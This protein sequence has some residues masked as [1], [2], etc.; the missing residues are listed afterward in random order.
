MRD[1]V[2]AERDTPEEITPILSY[3]ESANEVLRCAAVRALTGRGA[4]ARAALAQAL[5]DEDPD[6]RADAMEALAA[7]A[8]AQDAPLLRRSLTGDPVREVKLAAIEGLARLGDPE[9]VPLLRVLVH[10][11]SEDT[12]A[13]EDQDSDWE[14]W[15]DIQI[16]A[17]AALGRMQVSDAIVDMLEARAE[18]MAQALDVPVFDALVALG[19]AGVVSLLDVVEG[20]AGLARQR[21]VACLARL[22][23]EHLQDHV[24]ALLEADDP[25]LRIAGLRLLPADGPE[26]AAILRTDTAA[27]VR[28]A[29][30]DRAAPL[31][32]G[33]LT[34]AL[35]DADAAVQAAALRA[36]RPPLDEDFAAALADNLLAWVRGA[37]LPLMIAAA[38]ALPLWAP[39]RAQDALL[40]LVADG[41]RPL[42]ARIAA[43]RALA[44]PAVGTGTETLVSLLGNPAQ[45]VRTAVLVALTAR[46][47]AGDVVAEAAIA[48]AI[49]GVLL[50]D[51][52]AR[53]VRAAPDEAPDEAPDAATPKGE[54][55]GP[56]RIRITPDGEIVEGESQ[57]DPGGSTLSAILSEGSVQPPAPQ[58]EDTP[59]EST[60]KRRKRRPVEGPDE[61]AMALSREAMQVSADLP[62]APIG[63]ALLAQA[64]AAPGP[65]RAVAWQALDRHAAQAAL[66]EP[67][68]KTAQSAL[69]DADPVVRH[70]AYRLR[71]RAS[72]D[73]A[74]LARAA[75]EADPLIR[76]MAV[77]HLPLDAVQSALG[78]PALAVRRAAA[79]R[80]LDLAGPEDI[81]AAV[82][83][84]VAAERSDTLAELIGASPRARRA[85]LDLLGDAD[86]AA[87]TALVLL[88]ALAA[89]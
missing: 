79:L 43:V 36:L 60:A 7:C 58:G 77:P 37:A 3:L 20:E 78:D 13:W 48:Q 27:A 82:A 15:L 23:P 22:A 26:I 54:A 71:L 18:E 56:Q 41:A 59:E 5:L 12:V 21:A 14:D 46:A 73:P 35:A 86:I 4:E 40:A 53:Q 85:A 44:A 11:R 19:K 32:P 62:G 24:P 55:A 65:L 42:E 64:E 2:I 69:G 83:A 63:A 72:A 49:S 80:L 33:L 9:A 17:I 66:P 16:A 61:T 68:G 10:S 89:G 76:A 84:L 81:D 70:A 38:E 31:Q 88:Q 34:A 29:A 87:R 1:H 47:S 45:Q 6:V 51:A 74:T 30:L 8:T 28:L 52:E 57:A 25:V 50:S 67:A 75:T 39:Q